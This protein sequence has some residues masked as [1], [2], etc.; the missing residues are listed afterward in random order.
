M[1]SAEYMSVSTR[2]N[3]R[4]RAVPGGIGV[5]KYDQASKPMN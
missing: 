3:Y 2:G 4:K 5:A 1:P